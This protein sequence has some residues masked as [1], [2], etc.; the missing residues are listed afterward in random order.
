MTKT[1]TEL[2][3]CVDGVKYSYNRRLC[4]LLTKTANSVIGL[5]LPLG[6][7]ESEPSKYI[8][9]CSFSTLS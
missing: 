6:A 5:G 4:T 7:A 9:N 2:A 8:D 3:A 1:P